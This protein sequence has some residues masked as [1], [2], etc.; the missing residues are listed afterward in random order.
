MVILYATGYLITRGAS[1][2][3]QEFSLVQRTYKTKLLTDKELD[4]LFDYGV[5]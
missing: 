2:A 1:R 3:K 4:R 5:D